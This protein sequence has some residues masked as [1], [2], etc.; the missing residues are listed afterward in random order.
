MAKHP[1]MPVRFVGIPV[2]EPLHRLRTWCELRHGY[3]LPLRS[4]NIDVLECL[5]TIDDSPKVCLKAMLPDDIVFV[6]RS[7]RKHCQS[8]QTFAFL[9]VRFGRGDCCSGLDEDVDVVDVVPEVEVAD[10]CL[11]DVGLDQMEDLLQADEVDFVLV[12][13]DFESF[14]SD[15]CTGVHETADGGGFAFDIVL[16]NSCVE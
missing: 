4:T 2:H 10:L 9:Q 16:E 15:G 3:G 13:D 8:P 7:T 1:Y 12:K 5:D 11:A 6:G 14:C